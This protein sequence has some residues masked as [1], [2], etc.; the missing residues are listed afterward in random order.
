MKFG[1]VAR[2]DVKIT[3]YTKALGPIENEL[4]TCL[5][6]YIVFR[7]LIDR[8]QINSQ[9]AIMCGKIEA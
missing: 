8:H 1:N 9:V 6:G 2:E 4:I 5:G 7:T 3:K